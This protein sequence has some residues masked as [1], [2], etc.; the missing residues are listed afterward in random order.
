MVPALHE[1][2]AQRY[3]ID[4]EGWQ[5]S[6]SVAFVFGRDFTLTPFA[7]F[8][9]ALRLAAD[10]D[11]ESRQIDCRWTF[12]SHDER[13]VRSSCGLTLVPGY[14]YDD[15]PRFDYLVVVGGR[16]GQVDNPP[17]GLLSFLN[18][19]ATAGTP[20]IGLCT[21]GFLLA[22]AGLMENLRCCVHYRIQKEFTRRFPKSI[23]VTDANFVVDGGIVTCPGGVAAIDVAA[24][25]IDRHCNRIKARKAQNH[26]FA[27]PDE[28]RLYT[29]RRSY[30][31]QLS[32]ARRL[33]VEAVRIMEM[34]ID[35][36]L[37]VTQVAAMVG[38]TQAQLTRA[39]RWDLQASPAAFWRDMR[40][41]Q[42][43]H[44][45]LETS[46]SVT[47]IAYE[48]GFCDAAHFT[49]A[50]AR[51]FRMTPYNYRRRAP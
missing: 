28:P 2:P 31:D 24:Y 20:L 10:Y 23:A 40:L 43:R 33:T 25:L 8:V 3:S 50:F 46:R 4:A 11:D 37:R 41:E 42:A 19:V 45:L 44:L 39:F 51:T 6:L 1:N 35:Q 32:K 15:P 22:A 36:P 29:P 30:E 9:D 12:L 16:F 26:L 21:G 27:L 5:P 49:K 14:G 7:G 13:P 17:P 47:A 38:A 48:T 34:Y 18:R